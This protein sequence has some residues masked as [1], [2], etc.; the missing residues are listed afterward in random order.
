MARESF[1]NKCV[2]LSMESK[3]IPWAPQHGQSNSMEVRINIFFFRVRIKQANWG[4]VSEDLEKQLLDKEPTELDCSSTTNWWVT[5][6]SHFP[7]FMPKSMG[8][9]PQWLSLLLPGYLSNLLPFSP[10]WL[11]KTSNQ[12]APFPP[13]FSW[14]THCMEKMSLTMQSVQTCYLYMSKKT[15]SW[16]KTFIRKKG[17]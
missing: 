9:A 8:I 12:H 11:S 16:C 4:K 10:G 5:S 13:Q 6:T 17:W 7:Y 1:T 14:Y 2:G 3:C 15:S